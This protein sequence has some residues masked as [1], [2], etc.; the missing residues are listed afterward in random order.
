MSGA[1]AGGD[2][3]FLACGSTKA[4]AVLPRT[5][6]ALAAAWQVG[7]GSGLMGF[8]GPEALGAGKPAMEMESS[9]WRLGKASELLATLLW[10]RRSAGFGGLDLRHLGHRWWAGRAAVN[11]SRSPTT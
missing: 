4:E 9:S 3:W 10:S 1:A 7:P 11:A 8:G 2:A 5:Q 6:E